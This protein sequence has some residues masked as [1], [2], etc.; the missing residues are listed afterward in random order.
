MTIGMQ[1]HAA[2]NKKAIMISIARSPSA[3]VGATVAIKQI[4][5]GRESVFRKVLRALRLTPTKPV[6]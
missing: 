6:K 2:P 4:A 3:S 5:K 1:G